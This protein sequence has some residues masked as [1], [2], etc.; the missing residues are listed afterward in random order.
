MRKIFIFSLVFIFISDFTYCQTVKLINKSDSG[1]RGIW[2]SNQPSNDEYVFKYSGG[3]GTYPANHYPFSIYAPEVDKTFFCYGG[4]DSEGK[5]LLHMVS[6]FDHQSGMVPKPTIVMDKKTDD[7]HDNPVMNIDSE[8]YIWIFST[9][10]GVSRP[11]YI[12]RSKKPFDISEFELVDASKL[13]NGEEV[14]LDN[15]SY[16]QTY[17]VDG[18]GFLNLF[19][20]YD[21]DVIPGQNSKPRRTISFMTSEDG[22][23]YSGW[24]DIATIQEGHY[25]TSGIQGSK[26]A[27]SFNFHPILEKESGLNFRTNLYYLETTDFGDSWQT[28]GGEDL[29][30]PLKEKETPALV[31]DYESQGLLVYINDLNF[32]A[33]G[34]PVILFVTSKGYE[35]GPKNDPRTWR[36]ARF[37]GTEWEILPMTESDNNYDMGSLYID[38]KGTWRVIGPTAKGPQVYNT[39][40]EMELWTSKNQGESWKVK[41]ITRNSEY[42]HTYARRPLNTHPEFFAF[43]ADGHGRE[44][45]VSRL[46]FCDSKGKVYQL[47]IK[48]NGDFA[49]P[50]RVKPKKS[51]N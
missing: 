23:H 48:M 35:S 5:T 22:F 41:S 43:W 49:K 32:D 19:T 16:L 2:Y 27:S 18:D 21:R 20:H 7:A 28:A 17:F 33:E 29:L 13:E 34:N 40:G 8:G 25:Q 26:I 36:T 14:P 46:Y 4:T 39:G 15:F 37:T 51:K 38:K 45:S 9:S 47:P 11:S 31:V 50:L 24:K 3:L 1:Y 6:Y 44:K 10:H 30:L 12:S 42:N